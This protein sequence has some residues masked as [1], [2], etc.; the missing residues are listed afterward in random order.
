MGLKFRIEID[1]KPDEVFS[2][3][4]DVSRHG[5]WGN[6]ASNLSVT[7][8]S[9]G[10]IGSG[11]KFLSTQKFAGKAATA[12]ITIRTFDPPNVMQIAAVQGTPPKTQTYIH[13]F[14]LT[15]TANGTQ[16][17]RDIAR[18]NASPFAGL[19]MMLFYPAV[20]ADAMKGLRGLKAKLE[21]RPG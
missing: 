3:L 19:A 8:T 10:P 15:P 13:T 12:E 2:D 11:S 20:K 6:P 21:S 17:E 4:S 1:A 7:K 14:T 18:E 5:E 9:D 16:V